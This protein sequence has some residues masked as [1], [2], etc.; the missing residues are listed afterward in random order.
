MKKI[1]LVSDT[2]GKT[3]NLRTLMK[4]TRQ[5]DMLLHMGDVEGDEEEIRSFAGCPVY[6]V[7]GNCDSFSRLP[8]E[9]LLPLEGHRIFM[10]H[11][12]R[13][14]VSSTLAHLDDAARERDADIVLYGHTHVPE[15]VMIGERHFV[16]P[17]SLSRPRQEGHRPSY[18]ILE[19]D[20]Q[21]KI[22]VT[23]NEL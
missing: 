8:E 5:A 22:H 1:V 15:Y 6:F 17:G 10:T 21:G 3:A 12:H 2:H 4:R 9:E 13:Y 20:R 23:L 14:S 11:G 7:R 19:I 18:A 16:N